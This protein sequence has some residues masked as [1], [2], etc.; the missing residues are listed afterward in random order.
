MPRPPIVDLL[1]RA[2]AARESLFDDTHESAFR[3]FNGFLEGEP[4]LAIDVYAATAVLHDYGGESEA[5]DSL[6]R[7]AVSALRARLPWLRAAVLKTRAGATPEARRGNLIF[8]DA[9]DARISEHGISYAVNLTMNRDAS[10]YLD[11][12][13]LRRWT[14]ENLGGKSVLNTFACTGSLGVAAAAGGASEVVQLDLNRRFLEMA[15]ESLRLNNLP[16]ASHGLLAGDFFSH[17]ARLKRTG[18]R[19]DCVFLDPPFFATSARGVI[20]LASNSARLINKVRPLI[21]DGGH[22]VA[23]NNAL[24]VSGR[25]FLDTLQRLCAGGH[26]A[27]EELIPVPEDFTGYPDTRIQK[28]VTDPAPF[29]HS[30]KIA[31]LRVRRKQV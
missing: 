27:I 7:D 24:F 6:I 18:R 30:T 3:L 13:N 11:T 21:N 29:N 19:F 1:T 31:V 4:G 9:P 25:D 12:R 2:I 15:R 23:V 17:V 22:L 14:L 26:L 20:D 28:P 8:G 5:A 16:E 10:F